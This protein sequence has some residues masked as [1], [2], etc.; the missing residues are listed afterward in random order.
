MSII[1]QKY[2]GSSV[3]DV[4]RLRRVAELVAQTRREGHQVVVVVSAMGRTTD[5]LLERRAHFPAMQGKFVF[6]HAVT[7]MPAAL[8]EVLEVAGYS[9]DDLDMVIPHQAN[10]RIIKAA[11]KK[12]LDDAVD[13]SNVKLRSFEKTYK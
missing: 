7:K 1:V 5:E 8:K 4:Q 13:R 12:A 10:M 9:I 11:A 3:A 2:G 6:K